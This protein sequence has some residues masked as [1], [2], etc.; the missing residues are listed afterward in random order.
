MSTEKLNGLVDPAGSQQAPDKNAALHARLPAPHRLPILWIAVLY[1]VVTGR[2]GSYVGVPGLPVYIGD[3]LLALALVQVVLQL[4]RLGTTPR[5]VR[6]ALANSDR[7]LLICLSL[8]V[9]AAMRGV[10][11]LTSLADEPLLGLRDAAPYAYAGASLLAF[12]LPAAGGGRQWR[13]VYV[14]LTAHV[15]WLL[16]ALFLPLG[17]RG[18]LLLGGAPIFTSRP[19]FDS[20][21]AGAAIAFA[22]YDVLL[23]RRPRRAKSL[24]AIA[25]LVAA[26]G[27]AVANLQTRA[28]FLAGVVAIGV[29]LLIWATRSGARQEGQVGQAQRLLV[30]AA[31]LVVLAVVVA[32]SP[33]GQ[34]LVQAVRGQ[35]SQ[36]L[37]TAQVREYAWTGVTTYVF[38]DARRT[39]VGVG[40]GPDFVQDSGT[41]YSLEGTEYKDVRSPHNYILGTLGRLGLGGALLALL[42]IGAAARLAVRRLAGPA[43]AVTVIAALILLT[44]PVTALL[45]VVLESPFGAIPYFWAIGQ[46]ARRGGEPALV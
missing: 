4:R 2:W 29:V 5:A 12:L 26:N 38:A 19:D 11:S 34:R 3:I 36:A 20:A 45:G 23:G 30:L 32:F 41:A 44:L 46:L 1:L 16:V 22:V 7:A 42:M 40:F 24:A 35:D 17:L 8:F 21:V 33:P 13:L 31:S 9:W 43:D 14:A 28:G 10:L 6:H 27:V 39:A 15:G 25:I 18:H 37:G